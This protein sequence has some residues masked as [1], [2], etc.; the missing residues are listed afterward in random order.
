MEFEASCVGCG[1]KEHFEFN[2]ECTY[3]KC[4]KCG[5]EYLGGKDELLNLNNS[6]IKN[7]FLEEHGK[8]VQKELSM[9]FNKAMR[10]R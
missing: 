9:I 2:E 7:Q 5:K 3:I 6:F 4:S 10:Q 1:S 8:E